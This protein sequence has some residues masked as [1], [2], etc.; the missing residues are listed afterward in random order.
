MSHPCLTCS[1]RKGVRIPKLS[2]VCE[3]VEDEEGMYRDI[4]RKD[5]DHD[6]YK[7]LPLRNCFRFHSPTLAKRIAK[8][9]SEP[10]HFQAAK[11]YGFR[12]QLME[13]IVQESFFAHE[14]SEEF[15]FNP[16]ADFK[17]V[18][19]KM[20]SFELLEKASSRG[21]DSKRPRSNKFLPSRGSQDAFAQARTK[22]LAALSHCRSIESFPSKIF[23]RKVT[24]LQ[25]GTLYK[26][27]VANEMLIDALVVS[28]DQKM[29]YL[30]KVTDLQANS[31][32]GCA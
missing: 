27:K 9:I 8:E 17:V 10:A 31:T 13:I 14:N 18:N 5:K 6:Y 2:T 4:D 28:H 21:R 7:G 30:V 22:L 3:E 26:S 25:E 19:W 16:H 24:D 12:Y 11:E 20:D 23:T 1:P 29:V 32:C 15:E